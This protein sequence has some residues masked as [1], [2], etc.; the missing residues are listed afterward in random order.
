MSVHTVFFTSLAALLLAGC[1]SPNTE[2]PGASANVA[3]NTKCATITGSSVCRDPNKAQMG[4][5]TTMDPRAI[6]RA[7]SGTGA[8]T[9]ISD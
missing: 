5:V 9:T 2:A 8:A 7:H 1:A 4:N 3:R 6:E